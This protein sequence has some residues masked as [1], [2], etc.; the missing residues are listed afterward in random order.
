MKFDSSP[1]AIKGKVE[2]V[3]SSRRWTGKESLR[4]FSLCF[5][6]PLPV[7]HNSRFTNPF[8]AFYV[9]ALL[10]LTHFHYPLFLRDHLPPSPLSSPRCRCTSELH[11][12]E[13]IHCRGPVEKR[14]GFGRR[15]QSG[16]GHEQQAT[17]QGTVH[18]TV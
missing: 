9:F 10:S 12:Q 3:H 14:T 2:N 8:L 11:L 17:E 16:D 7:P 5:F 18:G 6:N 13:T 1:R 4:D 15:S